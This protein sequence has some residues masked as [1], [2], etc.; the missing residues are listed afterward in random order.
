MAVLADAHQGP[1]LARARTLIQEYVASLGIDLCFQGIDDELADL[2]GAYQPPQGA[3]LVALVDER[4]AGCVALRPTGEAGVAEL[5]RLFVRP[6]FRGH[7]LGRLLAES[8][9]ERARAAGF[10]SVRLDTLAEMQA[11]RALYAS[12]GFRPIPPYYDNPI[13]GAV[14]M[15]LAL[16]ARARQ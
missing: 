13:P 2:P 5:K 1:L 9:L 15:E 6:G 11:A 14:Y 4:E 10:K 7:D 8:A 12:L 16:P 3:L